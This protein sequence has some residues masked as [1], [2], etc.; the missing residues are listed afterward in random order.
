M[1]DVIVQA[2][3]PYSERE[4][5]VETGVAL[6]RQGVDTIILDCMGYTLEMKR[7][8]RAAVACPVILSRS[9]LARFAAGL[10]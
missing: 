4:E 1:S 3:S 2:A 7:H 6:A 8:I 9:V 10:A 5:V